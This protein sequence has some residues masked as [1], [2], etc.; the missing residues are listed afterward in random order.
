MA[1]VDQHRQLHGARTAPVRE[2]V[3]GGADRATR[4]EDVVDEHDRCDR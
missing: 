1:A 4:E 2:R 3:E